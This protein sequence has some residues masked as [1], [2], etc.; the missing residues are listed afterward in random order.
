MDP[1]LPGNSPTF[2]TA[3]ILLAAA[4]LGIVDIDHLVAF[5]KY[6]R[7]FIAEISR[8]MRASGLWTD[9]TVCTEFFFEGDAISPMLWVGCLAAHGVVAVSKKEDGTW[10]VRRVAQAEFVPE[11]SGPASQP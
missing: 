3:V 5:T 11:N 6:S 8:G 2:R 9:D 7:P 10:T 1:K 4:S